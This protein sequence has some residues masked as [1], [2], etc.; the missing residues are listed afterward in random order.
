M[1]EQKPQVNVS[2]SVGRD[3]SGS[4]DVH[5]VLES[6]TSAAAKPA[7]QPG[8]TLPE[9]ALGEALRLALVEYFNNGELR[10]LCFDMGIDYDSLAAEGKAGKARELV[11]HCRRHDC[12][13]DLYNRVARLRPRAALPPNIAE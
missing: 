3:N 13:A 12:L 8:E 11:D 10:D 7:R 2:I 5:N 6:D 4:I 1:S 9:P